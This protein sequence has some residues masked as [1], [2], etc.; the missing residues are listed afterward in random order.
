MVAF[1]KIIVFKNLS[2]QDIYQN[3]SS[4]IENIT[5]TYFTTIKSLNLY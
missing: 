3:T 1:R 4:Y 5:R 2:E